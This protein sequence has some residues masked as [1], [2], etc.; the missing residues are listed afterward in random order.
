M[1][2]T[3]PKIIIENEI[4]L[5]KFRNLTLEQQQIIL[6]LIKLIENNNLKTFETSEKSAYEMAK[7]WAGCVESG[8]GDLSTN[9]K[10]LE[11]FG[12]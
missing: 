5:D 7:Q 4:L 11:G 1:I 8:I 10:H 12:K 9:K 2:Q 3:T 6:D